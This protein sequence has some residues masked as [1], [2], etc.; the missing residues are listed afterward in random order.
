MRMFRYSISY[1]MWLFL[2]LLLDHYLPTTLP[3]A[4]G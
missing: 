3:N 2:A 1:L 4:L